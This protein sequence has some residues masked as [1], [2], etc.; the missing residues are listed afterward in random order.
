MFQNLS[1]VVLFLTCRGENIYFWRCTLWPAGTWYYCMCGVYK[2]KN[3]TPLLGLVAFCTKLRTST[4]AVFI[5][6]KVPTVCQDIRLCK[7]VCVTLL[8]QRLTKPC[9]CI[10]RRVPHLIKQVPR[11][12]KSVLRLVRYVPR[13]IYCIHAQVTAYSTLRCFRDVQFGMRT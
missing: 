12:I 13:P 6:A 5:L 10:T 8:G 9:P 2:C 4:L 7:T 1:H 11:L 3:I